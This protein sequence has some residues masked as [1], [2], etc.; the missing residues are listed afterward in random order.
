[1]TELKLVQ[2]ASDLSQVKVTPWHLLPQPSVLPEPGWSLG[3][4]GVEVGSFPEDTLGGNWP[5][6]G[7]GA[8]STIDRQSGSYS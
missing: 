5:G 6:T 1:M 2:L 3:V 7:E 8:E 4:S